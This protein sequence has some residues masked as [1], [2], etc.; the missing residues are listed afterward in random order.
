MHGCCKPTTV[1]KLTNHNIDRSLVS[2]N[3][4]DLGI[5]LFYYFELGYILCAREKSGSKLVSN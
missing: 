2:V 4:D 3:R 5:F 1:I